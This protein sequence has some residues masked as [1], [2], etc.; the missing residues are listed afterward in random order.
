[1]QAVEPAAEYRPTPQRVHAL[2]GPVEKYPAEQLAHAR[3]A[4]LAPELRTYWPAEH[5]PPQAVEPGAANEPT[6]HEMHGQLVATA[7]YV[8]AGQL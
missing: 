8:A 5:V 7:E 4:V 6:P 2:T 1:M 3:S